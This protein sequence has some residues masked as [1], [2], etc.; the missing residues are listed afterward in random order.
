MR[1]LIIVILLLTASCARQY[2]NEEC[3]KIGND[4]IA[5]ENI[6]KLIYFNNHCKRFAVGSKRVK[7]I[8]VT[9]GGTSTTYRLSY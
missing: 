1:Y 8:E 5:E 9:N 3:F 4:A 7:Y 6:L 2:T